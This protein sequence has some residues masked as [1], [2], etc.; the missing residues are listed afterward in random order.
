M[1]TAIWNLGQQVTAVTL[2]GPMTVLDM[3][4]TLESPILT[5]QV[6]YRLASGPLAPRVVMVV[7]ELGRGRELGRASVV[8]ATVREMMVLICLVVRELVL[9]NNVNM[10]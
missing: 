5:G 7:L 9:G 8:L 6:M 10:V 4:T 2:S 3:A 1:A